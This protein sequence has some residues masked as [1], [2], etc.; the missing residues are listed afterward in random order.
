M[1]LSLLAAALM[2]MNCGT[3]ANKAVPSSAQLRADEQRQRPIGGPQRHGARGTPRRT[4][5]YA[6][7]GRTRLPRPAFVGV[8]DQVVAIDRG[9]GPADGRVGFRR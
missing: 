2:K 9:V 4:G 6:A 3:K 5:Q 1:A 7:P 8:M